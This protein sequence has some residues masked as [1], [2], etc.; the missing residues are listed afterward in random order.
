VLSIFPRDVLRRIKEG[1]GSWEKMV[2]AKVAAAIKSRR[3]FGYSGVPATV[4]AK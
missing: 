4:A 3:L 1:D 2:P